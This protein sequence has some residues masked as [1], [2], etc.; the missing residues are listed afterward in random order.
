MIV[1]PDEPVVVLACPK[2]ARPPEHAIRF[3][4]GVRLPAMN[5][6]IER[7]FVARLDQGVNVIRHDAPGHQAIPFAVEIQKGTLDQSRNATL[8]QPAGAVTRILVAHQAT[9]QSRL[10]I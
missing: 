4:R 10:P 1:V 3:V 2:S 9:A 8:T 5:H 7:P 6:S